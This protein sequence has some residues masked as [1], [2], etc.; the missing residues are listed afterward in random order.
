M[1]IAF[2][3]RVGASRM[4]DLYKVQTILRIRV[5][6]EHTGMMSVI[7]FSIVKCNRKPLGS[8]SVS[9]PW[10]QTQIILIEGAFGSL[11]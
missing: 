2:V 10:P 4:L 5:V 9:F 8:T 1:M 7:E 3:S 6:R 11:E